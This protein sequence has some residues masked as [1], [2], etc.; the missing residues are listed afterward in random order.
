[1]TEFQVEKVF[2]VDSEIS[3]IQPTNHEGFSVWA[4]TQADDI[5][6][7]GKKKVKK[8]PNR[9]LQIQDRI[10]DQNSLEIHRLK[11]K[12]KL[13]QNFPDLLAKTTSFKGDSSVASTVLTDG[14]HTGGSEN[15]R[16]SRKRINP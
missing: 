13:A 14:S 4:T 7:D 12:C 3:E 16:T 15:K 6:L 10:S 2:G 9:E 8:T 5:S 11:E 1:M